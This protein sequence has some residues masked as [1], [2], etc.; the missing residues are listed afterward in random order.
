[1]KRMILMVVAMMSMTMTFAKTEKVQSVSTDKSYEIKIDMRRLGETLGLTFDQIEMVEGIYDNFNSE[2]RKASTEK[3][4]KRGAIIDKAVKK[5]DGCKTRAELQALNEK[6]KSLWSYQ[7]YVAY[8]TNKY[9][10]LQQ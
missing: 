5:I 9:N 1:M 10:T 6:C 2:M 4:Y 7:P 3:W 8:M